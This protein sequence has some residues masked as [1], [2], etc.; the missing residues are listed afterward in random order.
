VPHYN[1]LSTGKIFQQ[2]KKC[3][4]PGGTARNPLII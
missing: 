3:A 2:A 1:F 4:D